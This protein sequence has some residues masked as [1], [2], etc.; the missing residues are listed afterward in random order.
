MGTP[1][2]VLGTFWRFVMRLLF[3]GNWSC[4]RPPTIG[5]LFM[6]YSGSH[7]KGTPQ[8]YTFKQERQ[9]CTNYP[10][11]SQTHLSSPLFLA[12]KYRNIN[13][14]P[15][16]VRRLR[17]R[18]GTTNSWL[19]TYC[20]ETLGL[21]ADTIFTYLSCYYCQDLHWG[22]IHRTSQPYFISTPTPPYRIILCSEYTLRYRW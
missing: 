9:S 12:S 10:L 6:L 8:S 1:V 5:W 20:Q 15:F 3:T 7:R 18:L 4:L 16:R 2:S 14:F 13:L 19:T 11:P 21:S 22:T 17:R